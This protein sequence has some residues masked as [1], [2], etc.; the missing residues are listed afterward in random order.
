MKHEIIR[1]GIAVAV[2]Y[3]SMR[4]LTCPVEVVPVIFLEDHER[5]FHLDCH[6]ATVHP[7]VYHRPGGMGWPISSRILR[8]S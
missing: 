8:R 3:I 4:V 1:S 2:D 5:R 7:Q 6:D